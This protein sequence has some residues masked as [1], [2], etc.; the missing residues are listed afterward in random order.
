MTTGDVYYYCPICNYRYNLVG[1]PLHGNQYSPPRYENRGWDHRLLGKIVGELKSDLYILDK[2]K[3]AY[4][5]EENWNGLADIE[6]RKDGVIR[7]L[8][9]LSNHT[10]LEFEETLE[11]LGLRRK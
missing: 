5:E 8:E 7:F 6:N 2:M 9:I 1:C 4:I 3:R 10:P 11:D